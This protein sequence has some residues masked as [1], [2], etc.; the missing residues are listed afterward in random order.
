MY[1]I[2]RNHSLPPEEADLKLI[3]LYGFPTINAYKM[4]VCF[5]C[6]GHCDQ[7]QGTAVISSIG[8]Q[9]ENNKEE[10]VDVHLPS[11]HETKMK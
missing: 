9:L 8:W 5:H 3:F 11:F 7:I 4:V 1:R 2:H 6:C 10:L